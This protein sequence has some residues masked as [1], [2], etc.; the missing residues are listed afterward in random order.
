MAKK[1]DKQSDDKAQSFENKM[2][3][4]EEIVNK[5]ESSEVDL[6]D[7]I[8]LFEEGVG[9]SKECQTLLDTAEEKVKI[10]T[11]TSTGE[12]EAKDFE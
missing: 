9:L 4:L 11:Q 10:L 12:T 2:K 5:M 1:D 3:R 8:K 6:E 7:S